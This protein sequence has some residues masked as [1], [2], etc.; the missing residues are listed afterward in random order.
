MDCHCTC[1]AAEKSDELKTDVFNPTL[2]VAESVVE[3]RG[4]EHVINSLAFVTEAPLQQTK[5]QPHHHSSSSS[6]NSNNTNSSPRSTM[7]HLETIRDYLASGSRDRTVRL[8]KISQGACVA[9]F[10]AHE[11]W[12]QSV[13]IHP[14]GNYIIS[15]AD[16]KSIRVFDI[17]AQRCLRTLEK[18]HNHFITSIAMHHTLP[19]LV[20]GSVD[21]TLRCWQL[22]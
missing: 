22:D 14:T 21:Q 17:A 3:L 18:A 2:W 12:V 11:N 7:T 13:V 10:K 8:W 1:L 16:D 9:V 5:E 6:I 19:V 4:H 20:S 15:C